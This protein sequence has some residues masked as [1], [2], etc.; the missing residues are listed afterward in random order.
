MS[1]TLD[2]IIDIELGAVQAFAVVFATLIT[3]PFVILGL[4][5][6]LVYKIWEKSK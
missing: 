5:F 2:K 6:Y 3:L 1:N 4:P